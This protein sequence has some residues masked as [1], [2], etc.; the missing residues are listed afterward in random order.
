MKIYRCT[1]PGKYAAKMAVNGV[2]DEGF[3]ATK[4]EAEKAKFPP[5]P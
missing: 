2:I 4:A 1:S 3:Y 5:K